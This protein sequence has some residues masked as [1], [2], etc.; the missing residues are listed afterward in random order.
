MSFNDAGIGLFPAGRLIGRIVVLMDHAIDYV[1]GWL[2]DSYW[3][4]GPGLRDTVPRLN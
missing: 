3:P 2:S 4:Y 1:P